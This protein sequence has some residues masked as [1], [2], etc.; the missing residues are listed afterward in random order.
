MLTTALDNQTL[1]TIGYAGH[2][3]DSF[4]RALRAN[5]I[6]IL[7]DVRMT[8]IS[9]KKGFSKRALHRALAEAGINYFHFRPLGSPAELRHN[10][11]ADK[12]YD[13]FFSAFRIYLRD[14]KQSVSEAAEL[15]SEGNA[16][17]MCVEKRPNECHRSVV[18]DAIA[19]K[20]GHDVMIRHIPAP[21]PTASTAMLAV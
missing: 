3:L 21:T 1:Y 15:V 10:L 9:R 2:T 8:P 7:L 16:C 6:S 12:N 17:L 13:A 14:Q 19:E 4:V 20:L 11:W 18:A 5:R